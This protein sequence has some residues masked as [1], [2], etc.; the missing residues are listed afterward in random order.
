MELYGREQRS[1]EL[2]QAPAGVERVDRENVVATKPIIAERL[3]RGND[4]I[5][6]RMV[7][8]ILRRVGESALSRSVRIPD[9]LAGTTNDGW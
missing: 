6:R 9:Q 7:E 4:R 5:L 1:G 2:L 3:E 8:E